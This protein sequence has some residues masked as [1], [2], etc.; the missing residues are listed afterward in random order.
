MELTGVARFESTGSF[1]ELDFD[2]ARYRRMPKSE[3]PDARRGQPTVTEV[4]VSSMADLIWHPML[5]AQMEPDSLGS[6]LR[7][8][9]TD[10]TGVVNTY[11][12]STQ[13]PWFWSVEDYSRS[14]G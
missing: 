2:L 9:T 13:E 6:H 7:L 11:L 10:G 8:T 1:W 3:N 14:N 5:T 4:D 12:D